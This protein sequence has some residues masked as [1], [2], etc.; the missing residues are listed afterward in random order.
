MVRPAAEH[1]GERAQHVRLGREQP[2]LAQD[3]LA[4]LGHRLALDAVEPR[5][6][7]DRARTTAQL[8]VPAQE[9]LAERG[10]VDGRRGGGLRA[11]RAGGAGGRA[12]GRGGHRD[13]SVGV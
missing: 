10:D 7:G 8:G 6:G 2:E 9:L 13:S 1:L 12:V 4:V 3:P 11:G 5:V